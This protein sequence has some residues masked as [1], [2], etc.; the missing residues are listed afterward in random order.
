MTTPCEHLDDIKEIKK[1]VKEMKD[2][3]NT[4]RLN[5]S[6]DIA[7]LKSEGKKSGGR[8]GGF[9]GAIV[10]IVVALADIIAKKMGWQ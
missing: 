2:S 6:V 10:V 8:A 5:A 3:F 9:S 4:F 1:D 7:T